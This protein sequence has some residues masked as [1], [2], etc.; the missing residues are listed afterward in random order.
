M[1]LYLAG[2]GVG[3]IG[4]VDDD[5]IDVSNLQRQTV[6]TTAAVGTSKAQSAAASIRRLNPLVNVEVHETRLTGRNAARLLSAYDL[7]IDGTDNFDARYLANDTAALLG[8]PYVW[9]SVLRFDGQVSVF[10]QAEAATPSEPAAVV[11]GAAGSGASATHAEPIEP[12][13]PA[14]TVAGAT[15]SGATAAHA[16]PIAARRGPTLRDVF[17]TP[18]NDDDVES[19][20]IAGVLGPLCATVGAAMATEAMK[21]IVGFGDLLLG[22]ILVVDALD[23]SYTTVEFQRS[24]ASPRTSPPEFTERRAPMTD[25][26][27]AT[28]AP[29]PAPAPAAPSLTAPELAARLA[30]REQGTDDFV[31]V[32]VR[33]PWERELVAIPGSAL[34]P[35]SSILS[36][37]A[38]EIM[39]RDETVIVHCH[40]D[41]RSRHAREVLLQAGWSNVTFVEGGIDAWATE[42]DP[43]QPR[44]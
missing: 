30:A 40:H 36:D 4:V 3:T 5:T 7:V 34:V 37:A 10:W 13:E 12:A 26:S 44:Y 20:A 43:S 39:P 9:G 16:E 18:P 14:A 2:A 33:E 25:E 38:Q 8:M 15:G 28:P 35:L 24:P 31:L 6:H 17:P 22:R 11:T 1:L 27:A 32:D 41:G 23:S 42:V 19:C 21:L 29:T